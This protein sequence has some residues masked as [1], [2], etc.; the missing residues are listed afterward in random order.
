[1][2]TQRLLECCVIPGV[3]RR[4][5]DKICPSLGKTDA[6]PTIVAWSLM[7]TLIHICTGAQAHAQ[8]EGGRVEAVIPSSWF[9]VGKVCLSVY[10]CGSMCEEQAPLH[11]ARGVCCWRSPGGFPVGGA[12]PDGT[13]KGFGTSMRSGWRVWI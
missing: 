6:A 5:W 9:P 11:Y 10:P 13:L 7:H 1:M 2:N 8:R 3:R 4:S 12:G